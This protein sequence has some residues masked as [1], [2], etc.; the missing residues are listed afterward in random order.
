MT[1][2]HGV[3]VS[4]FGK[5][6]WLAACLHNWDRHGHAGDHP[7]VPYVRGLPVAPM[8]VDCPPGGGIGASAATVSRRPYPLLCTTLSPN[9]KGRSRRGTCVLSPSFHKYAYVL[10]RSRS[11]R[12]DFLATVCPPLP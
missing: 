8:R 6:R 4:R 1:R 5:S 7:V 10:A 3:V 12:T 11:S 2:R 9:T